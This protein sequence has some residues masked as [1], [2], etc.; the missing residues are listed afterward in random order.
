MLDDYNIHEDDVAEGPRQ[1]EWPVGSPHPLQPM[2]G[3]GRFQ[4]Q[5]GR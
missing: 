3:M 4:T 1:R 5:Q 2:D